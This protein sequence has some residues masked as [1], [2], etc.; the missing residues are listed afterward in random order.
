MRPRP[1]PSRHC[2]PWLTRRCSSCAVAVWPA[3][4]RTRKYRL[5]ARRRRRRTPGP[6]A[7]G[8]ADRPHPR[9][10]RRP[11]PAPSRQPD[12]IPHRLLEVRRSPRLHL[13]RRRLRAQATTASSSDLDPQTAWVAGRRG[14]A[15]RDHRRGHEAGVRVPASASI[16]ALQ[17]FTVAAWAYRTSTGQ[18]YAS[19]ISRQIDDSLLRAVQPVVHREPGQHLPGRPA[20]RAPYPFVTRSTRNTPAAQWI[21][22]AATYDGSRLRLYLDGVEENTLS[23]ARPPAGGDHAALPRQ[24]QEPQRRRADGRP[25]RRRP[26]LLRSAA[27]RRHRRPGRGRGAAGP[28]I[29]QRATT[30]W[31]DRPSPSIPSSTTSPAFR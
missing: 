31:R 12:P 11:T 8:R 1:A 23:Y 15:L 26:A 24:Q 27:P 5:S 20:S 2:P 29:A 28:L 30:R 6:A 25:H 17:R 4:S 16:P 19:V 7:D 21:H 22:V 3:P 14:G 13:G 9:E 18:D 10:R